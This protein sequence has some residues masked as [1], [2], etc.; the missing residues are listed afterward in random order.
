MV[1]IMT[2]SD[3]RQRI[4]ERIQEDERLRGDLA[5]EAARALVEW[6]VRRAEAAIDAAQSDESVDAAVMAIRAAARAAAHSGATTAQ[7]VIA[8]AEAA[9]AL[10]EHAH[11]S[12]IAAPA[13]S[14]ASGVQAGTEPI[15]APPP[16]MAM[17]SLSAPVLPQ[18]EPP[19]PQPVTDAPPRRRWR[20][21]NRLADWLQRLRKER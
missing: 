8:K 1:K 13:D 6:A 7:E 11:V 16:I 21:R 9:L 4:I 17:D 20:W 14:S 3:R 19:I 15:D 5:G 2:D 12:G 10:P 18:P